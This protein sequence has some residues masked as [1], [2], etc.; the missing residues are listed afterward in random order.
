MLR[1]RITYI[2]LIKVAFD[3]IGLFLDAVEGA[4]CGA[5]AGQFVSGRSSLGDALLQVG[6]EELVRIQL[7]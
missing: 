7:R 5:G 4:D 2:F 1:S 3:S 6:I